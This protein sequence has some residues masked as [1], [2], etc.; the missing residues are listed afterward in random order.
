MKHQMQKKGTACCWLVLGLFILLC[1]A[2]TVCFVYQPC[3]KPVVRRYDNGYFVTEQRVTSDVVKWTLWH[4]FEKRVEQVTELIVVCNNIL[5]FMPT[6]LQDDGCAQ[7]NLDIRAKI[8]G[9]YA[10]GGTGGSQFTFGIGPNKPNLKKIENYAEKS[11]TL[12][13]F[14]NSV[15]RIKG[16]TS[17]MSSVLEIET[18]CPI[19]LFDEIISGLSQFSGRGISIIPAVQ[20]IPAHIPSSYHPQPDNSTDIKVDVHGL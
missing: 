4:S 6:I 13:D 9:L 14:S 18:P 3:Q 15:Y 5:A 2:G 10:L 8:K 12:S 20:H 1:I 7:R 16:Y 11:M 19:M 17:Q